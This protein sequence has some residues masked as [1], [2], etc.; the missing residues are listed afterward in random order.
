MKLH[1]QI[2]LGML[3]G[4]ALGLAFGPNAALLPHDVYQLSAASQAELRL[5]PDQGAARAAS[6]GRFWL[7]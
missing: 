3:A 7:S 2:L 1:T 6:Q 4:A 5:T